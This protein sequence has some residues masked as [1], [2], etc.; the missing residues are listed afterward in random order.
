MTMEA[1]V[2]VGMALLTSAMIL[3]HVISAMFE[4]RFFWAL[5]ARD[6]EN[7]PGKFGGRAERALRN[8]IEASAMYVP[9]AAALL[10][11]HAN[12]VESANGAAIFFIARSVYAP[13]YWI[14]IPYLRTL[15]FGVGLAGLTM[16]AV[17]AVQSALHIL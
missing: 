13:V 1:A 15:V 7:P 4:G 16:M 10:F 11:S 12:T 6:T 2:L 17:P 8:Q 9:L 3:V 14:G 5:T